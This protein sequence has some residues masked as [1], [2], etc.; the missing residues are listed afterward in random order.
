N[1]LTLECPSNIV[2]TCQSNGAAVNYPQP[3]VTDSCCTNGYTISYNPPFGYLFPP[4]STTPV[5]V[6][7]ADSCGHTNTCS[8]TVTVLPGPQVVYVGNSLEVTNGAPDYDSPLVILGEYSQA[9]PLPTSAKPLPPGTAQDVRF[10][11]QIYNF[12]LYALSPVA[13]G[14]YAHEQTFEVVASQSFSNSTVLFPTNQVLSLS[15]F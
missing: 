8:F 3:T 12:T 13:T 2:V 10:Y 6:T 1:C 15:N 7:V 11:G 5:E 4:S 9:G 14:P